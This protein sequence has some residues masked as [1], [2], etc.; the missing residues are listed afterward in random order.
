MLTTKVIESSILKLT[1]SEW[2]FT[3]F[4]GVHYGIKKRYADGYWASRTK[5]EKVHTWEEYDLKQIMH[6]I[7]LGENYIDILFDDLP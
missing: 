2:Y 6:I 5:A 3:I 1:A 4:E 7:K